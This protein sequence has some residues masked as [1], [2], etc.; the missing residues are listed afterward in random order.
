VTTDFPPM[1][2]LRGP[3]PSTPATEAASRKKNKPRLPVRRDGA[4]L[5]PQSLHWLQPSFVETAH[6]GI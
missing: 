6:Q 4:R 3:T 2:G 1:A 5:S